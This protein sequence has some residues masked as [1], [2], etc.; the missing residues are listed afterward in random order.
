MRKLIF[1]ACLITA[2]FLIGKEANEAMLRAA[3]KKIGPTC[4]ALGKKITAKDPTSSADAKQLA[5][6]FSDV[7]KFW[8]AK[9]S[10]DA[11]DFTKSATAEFKNISKL[12]AAGKWDEAGAA[13]KKATANCAGCHKAH[14]EK[15]A[16]GSYSVK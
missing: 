15:A 8:K 4:S 1:V 10:T 6:D 13:F 11:V 9:K 2:G 5:Q 7:H 12:T 16:D 3:M 14:R